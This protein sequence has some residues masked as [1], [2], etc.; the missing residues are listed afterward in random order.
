VKKLEEQLV[1]EIQI[2]FERCPRVC[3]FS[4]AERLVRAEDGAR[5]WELYVSDIDAY[6][7]AQPHEL[8]LLLGEICGVL[9]EV[10]HEAPQAADLLPGRTFA[11]IWH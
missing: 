9:A 1:A 6:P 7:R 3:G 11:R 4:V 10:L 8:D 2:V 5:E